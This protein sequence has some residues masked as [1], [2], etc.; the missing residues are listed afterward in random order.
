M[1]AIQLAIVLAPRSKNYDRVG[2]QCHYEEFHAP[3]FYSFG[4]VGV[5]RYIRNHIIRFIG[6]DPLFDTISEFGKYPDKQAELI[7]ALHSPE[8]RALEE[9]VHSFLAERGNVFN[10]TEE[11]IAGPPRG[12]E[13]GPAEKRMILLKRAEGVLAEAFVAAARDY[14]GAAAED[15]GAN[16]SRVALTLWNPNPT[17]PMD[18]MVTIWPAPDAMLPDVH[19][20]PNGI[21]LRHVLDVESYCTAWH[22]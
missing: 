10:V 20:P 4:K 16:A 8:A 11:L 14:A 22:D 19:A 2:F 6:D 3:L 15:C 13:P 7:A 9:D 21:V 1:S 17:P 18:A 5:G 12:F